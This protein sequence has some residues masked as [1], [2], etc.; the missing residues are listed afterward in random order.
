MNRTASILIIVICAV[1]LGVGALWYV[2]T[3]PRPITEYVPPVGSETPSPSGHVSEETIKRDQ[4]LKKIEKI[5][6]EIPFRYI[7]TTPQEYEALGWRRYENKEVGFEMYYPSDWRVSESKGGDMSDDPPYISISFAPKTL[8]VDFTFGL[9]V[10]KQPLKERLL[11]I[12]GRGGLPVE[13]LRVNNIDAVVLGRYSE[14]DKRAY[15][16]VMFGS[17]NWTIGFVSEQNNPS[18]YELMFKSFRPLSEK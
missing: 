6:D 2:Q 8:V 4:M 7:R 13:K 12:A 16:N 1:L 5:L 9:Y 3:R 11:I 14:K 10:Y 17:D 18:V 15:G